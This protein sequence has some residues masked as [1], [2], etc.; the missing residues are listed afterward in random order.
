MSGIFIS[1]THGDQGLAEELA[2]LI[3]NLFG[4][5]RVKVNFSSK[6][7]LDGGISPGDQ[8]FRWIVD[9]VR[10]AEVAFILLTPASIQK[11][12]V[13]WEAGAVAG[14]AFAG[15]K[16]ERRVLPITSGIKSAD[17]PTPFAGTQL[18]TG[19]GEADVNKLVED[20]Y[21]RFGKAA[22]TTSQ[23]RRFWD[24][25]SSAVEKYLERVGL[26]LRKLPL[27]ITEAAIQEWLG[28][29]DEL[30]QND[31][32]SET[33]VLENWIDITFGREADDRKRPIDVRIHRRLGELY[34]AAGRASDAARQLQLARQ[35]APRDIF[36]LRRLGKALL[37]QKEFKA[38]ETVLL[39]IE[40]LD[41]TAFERNSENAALR[42][43]WYRENHDFL[44]EREV[45]EA[46][47]HN[48]PK[49]YYLGD[50]LGQP[51]LAL[52]E[53]AKAKEIYSQV[54][55]I[56]SDL[57]EQN[58][59]TASTALSAAVVCDDT[60]AR[61]QILNELRAL[62]PS[63]GELDSIERGLS[64]ILAAL[65]KDTGIVDELRAM[66]TARGSEAVV[67]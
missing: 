8:W 11:P 61:R 40:D 63:R 3:D 10:D 37:D 36:I 47:Y 17:I 55:A 46:A 50:L 31:R 22:F 26:M 48:N 33:E 45:L 30:E 32:A 42:A 44:K 13:L 2:Q 65:G 43:R 49:S 9:Q 57:R 20:L 62:K 41:K 24:S 54:L 66:A 5:D 38:A 29:L 53:N 51:L 56:L 18:L 67:V 21:D 4:K 15:S 64:R 1:H 27:V 25:R 14:A 7:E 16:E 23:N 28:R 59:W 6:K 58:V 34:S 60:E 39:D 52:K 12:W 19:T 35:L